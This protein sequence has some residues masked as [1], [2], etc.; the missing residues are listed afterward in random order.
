MRHIT[1]QNIRRLWSLAVLI[2]A[3]QQAE[4]GPLDPN[5]F[6]LSGTGAFPTLP[7]QYLINTSGTPTIYGPVGN[8]SGQIY[9]GLAVFDF[10]SLAIGSGQTFDATGALPLVLLSRGD[11]S[12]AGT[13][14]VSGSF[15]VGGPGG[16]GGSNP[17]PG[18]GSYIF[19][20]GSGGGFGGVGGASGVYTFTPPL[21]GQPT[22]PIPSLPGGPSYGNLTASL[23][24]GSAGGGGGGISGGPGTAIVGGGGAGGGAIEIG[25]VEALTVNGGTILANGQSEQVIS[26]GGSGGGIFLHGES[27]IVTGSVSADGGDGG[28]TIFNGGPGGGEGGGGGG[29]GGGRILVEYGSDF[30]SEA[31]AIE[32]VGGNAGQGSYGTLTYGLY[33]GPF[34]TVVGPFAPV[35]V[36]EP[37]SLVLGTIA[38]AIALGYRG[39]SRRRNRFRLAQPGRDPH[40]A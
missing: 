20:G 2:G 6:A 39:A 38:A 16:G 33:G 23:Q 12:I 37:S 36:P 17:G 10:S 5:A 13:L 21:S 40:M 32:A 29:G 15:G 26:G 28:S 8:I 9:N 30:V 31:G 3:V 24:G 25:A 14:N 4:A 27:V 18:A 34:T 11:A 19:E 7:G 35:G 22:P 1:G